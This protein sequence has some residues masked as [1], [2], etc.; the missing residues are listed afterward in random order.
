M[1]AMITIDQLFGIVTGRPRL[2][3][4]DG[5][6]ADFYYRMAMDPPLDEMTTAELHNWKVYSW[7]MKI[8]TV[9]I[10][11]SEDLGDATELAASAVREIENWLVEMVPDLS[12]GVAAESKRALWLGKQLSVPYWSYL[13]WSFSLLETLKG[14]SAFLDMASKYPKAL[15][16]GLSSEKIQRLTRLVNDVYQSVREGA[17]EVKN[18]LGKEGVLS[19]LLDL[20]LAKGGEGS[21]DIGSVLEE[22]TSNAWREIFCGSLIDS[23]QDAVDGI[24]RIKLL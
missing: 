12:E 20:I 14:L 16:V 10:S 23:W 3:P 1:H 19:N 11:T 8:V 4:P 2:M 9:V 22:L 24:V 13:H 6:G 15:L 5:L 7:L 17:N 18:K 21:G